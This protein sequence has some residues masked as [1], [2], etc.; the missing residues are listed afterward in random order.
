[1]D[2]CPHGTWLTPRVE[3]SREEG[4]TAIGHTQAPCGTSTYGVFALIRPNAVPLA[5]RRPRRGASFCLPSTDGRGVHFSQT[6][7]VP[8]VVPP[9][10]AGT[11][12]HTS[13]EQ[14]SGAQRWNW[15]STAL[16]SPSGVDVSR[17]EGGTAVG[18]SQASAAGR[19]RAASLLSCGPTQGHTGVQA[20]TP[21]CL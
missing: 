17:Q 1:M 2:L 21:W 20:Y 7:G 13:T 19:E 15:V 18:L 10:A 16:G 14:L 9:M 4:G 6:C 3:G 12:G 8:P 5:V 11:I